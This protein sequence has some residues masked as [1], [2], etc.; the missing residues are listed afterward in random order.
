[1]CVAFLFSVLVS[2]A[3]GDIDWFVICDIG[4]YSLFFSEYIFIGWMYIQILANGIT[5][6]YL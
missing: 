6:M 4:I 3:H 2:L 1:M 5:R